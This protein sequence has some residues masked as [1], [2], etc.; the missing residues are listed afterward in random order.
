MKKKNWLSI[1]SLSLSIIGLVLVIL[2]NISGIWATGKIQFYIFPTFL[3]ALFSLLIGMFSLRR[4]KKEK[5][6]TGKIPAIL[7]IIFGA[8]L[9]AFIIFLVT[10]TAYSGESQGN[11]Q[12]QHYR[13]CNTICSEKRAN[14]TQADACTTA[15][16][17][18][19]LYAGEEGFNGFI[20]EIKNES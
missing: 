14:S 12:L 9:L 18:T 17:Q 6:N 8:I 15:C 4:I 16:Y 11:Q 1:L 2:P 20:A 3:L 5:I 19:Y 13:E 7:G 10:F